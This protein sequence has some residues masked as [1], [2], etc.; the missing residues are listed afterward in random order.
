MAK[1]LFILILII[2][3]CQ[4]IDEGMVT[5]KIP[6]GKHYSDNRY[7][8]RGD[9]IIVRFYVDSSWIHREKNPG[10]N[11][12]IGLSSGVDPQQ[13]S[14]RVAWRC[15]NDEIR[16]AAM[17]HRNGSSPSFVELACVSPG[18]WYYARVY[19]SF[20][21]QS[22]RSAYVVEVDG[23]VASKSGYSY[24]QNLYLCHPYFGGKDPA[25]H[26]MYFTF[27]FI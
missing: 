4:K 16:I 6:K 25:P 21:W 3:S 1:Y 23:A 19:Q 14:A 11:K 27:L 9:L 7:V 20:D 13:N 12:L 26:D 10:W 15:I 8:A 24:K 2:S 5:H 22:G 18:V 17:F